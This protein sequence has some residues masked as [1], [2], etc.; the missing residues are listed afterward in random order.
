MSYKMLHKNYDVET[1]EIYSPDEDETIEK[2]NEYWCA[3]CK[4]ET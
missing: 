2:R 3:E 4:I 1:E